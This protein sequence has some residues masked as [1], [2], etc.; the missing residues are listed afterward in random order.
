M[1]VYIYIRMSL[2]VAHLVLALTRYSFTPKLSRT[3]LS[4]FTPPPPHLHC[5]H[6]CNTIADYC[7]IYD[8]PHDPF[9]MSYTIHY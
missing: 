6:Y 3:S 4:S 8:P 1:Y 7:A 9:C 5:S 2:R